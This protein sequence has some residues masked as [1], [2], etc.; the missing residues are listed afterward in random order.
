MAL[1][2]LPKIAVAHTGIL[3]YAVDINEKIA[4]IIMVASVISS[5]GT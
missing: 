3:Q 4:I 1:A 5:K 2:K